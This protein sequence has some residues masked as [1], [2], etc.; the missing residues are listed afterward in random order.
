MIKAVIFDLYETLITEWVSKKYTSRQCAEDLGVDYIIFR[1]IW[2]S[3]HQEMYAG[4][5]TYE[6]TI[7]KI[8]SKAGIILTPDKLFACRKRRTETKMQCF[9]YR[10]DDILQ[11]LDKLKAL[12]YKLALCSNCFAEEVEPLRDSEIYKRFDNVILSYEVGY[13][14]P[15]AKIYRLCTEK[16]A[17]QP[18]ECLYIG[19]G[20]S[21][22]LFG[23]ENVGMKPLRAM[24]FLDKYEKNI[25]EMPF[26]QVH[27]PDEVVQLCKTAYSDSIQ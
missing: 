7:E 24:W 22:E 13:A 25:K 11:M 20:G 14:K 5:C 18:H 26:D 21:N 23:A 16:L 12:G 15:D 19:D 10:N 9:T 3:L 27:Q 4:L 8:C 2:E 6:Q 17:V 1:G